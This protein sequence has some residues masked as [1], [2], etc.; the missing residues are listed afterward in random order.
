VHLNMCCI[1]LS[2]LVK[3]H[4]VANKRYVDGA[5]SC[6]DICLI[7]HEEKPPLRGTICD[8][9]KPT[10]KLSPRFKDLWHSK[11]ENRREAN[12]LLEGVRIDK[13]AILQVPSNYD[14][15]LARKLGLRPSDMYLAKCIFRTTFRG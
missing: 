4:L 12:V 9:W 7:E 2:Y 6:Q 14:P 10:R 11:I 13:V 5:K 3:F 15:V 8:I 1:A